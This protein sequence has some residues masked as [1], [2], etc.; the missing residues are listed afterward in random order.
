MHVMI[1]STA[2]LHRGVRPIR[3]PKDVDHFSKIKFDR[4]GWES[5]YHPKLEEWAWAGTRKGELNVGVATL[6]EL[7]T[8]KLSHSYWVLKNGSWDKHIYDMQLMK[9]YGAKLILPL[10]DL[11]YEVWED[12]YGKKS[13]NFN[14]SADTFFKDAV[15]R[16]Y[17]HDSVHES[18]AYGD[19]PMFNKILTKPGGVK[20]S[21]KKFNALTFEE[22]CQLLR[23]EVYATA[24]ERLI[25]PNNYHYNQNVAYYRALKM[26]VTSQ[27]KGWFPRWVLDNFTEVRIPDVNY[28]VR[29]KENME[30]LVEL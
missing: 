9:K 4:K 22:K 30:K 24:L 13:V 6:D 17:D 12:T 1:G 5:F 18:I 14:Q 15:T 26:L 20:V 8:I 28:V 21:E 2:M 25:I 29:H 11:L 23:E 3:P 27:S 16:K 7:Y 19:E 10:H